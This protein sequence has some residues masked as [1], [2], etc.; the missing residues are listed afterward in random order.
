VR[1]AQAEVN[2]LQGLIDAYGA[3]AAE[4][5]RSYVYW[6]DL[7]CGF[8]DVACEANRVARAAYFY[9]RYSYWTGLRAGVAVP[10]AVADAALA[11]AR[12]VL[13]PIE[14]NLS[15]ARSLVALL[16]DQL[17]EATAAVAAARAYLDTLPEIRGSLAP[18][19]TIAIE[20]GATSASVEARFRGRK[21]ADGRVSLGSP[22]EA[23]LTLPVAGRPE[24]CSPL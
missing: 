7:G 24:L 18:V 11:A 4:A 2:R 21:L 3:E 8:L 9:G 22:G 23:C 1:S 12:A 13:S 15:N 19:V 10:K 20:N 16:E 6:R 17:D 14:T 5:W